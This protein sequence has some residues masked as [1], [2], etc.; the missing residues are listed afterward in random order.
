MTWA[1]FA[2][3]RLE[4]LGRITGVE[5]W[6]SFTKGAGGWRLSLSQAVSSAS[7]AV[8][9]WPLWHRSAASINCLKWCLAGM[10][11]ESVTLQRSPVWCSS[12]RL[13]A[14][15]V[16]DCPRD[17]ALLLLIAL[18]IEQPPSYPRGSHR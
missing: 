11:R 9:A 4:R 5:A 3:G 13:F 15:C 6:V 2:L 14:C 1:V 16:G 12:G 17:C 8:T 7:R 18:P 10:R